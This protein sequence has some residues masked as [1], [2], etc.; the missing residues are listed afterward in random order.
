MLMGKCSLKS[1]FEFLAFTLIFEL[2][3]KFIPIIVSLIDYK[4][5]IQSILVNSI[6]YIE[7]NKYITL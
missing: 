7:I 6:D 3:C 1:L 5:L 2:N 4:I